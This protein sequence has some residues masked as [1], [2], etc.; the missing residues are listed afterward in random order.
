MVT[1]VAGHPCTQTH[2][3]FLPGLTRAPAL[4][5][6][7]TLLIHVYFDINFQIQAFSH[8]PEHATGTFLYH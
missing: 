4:L 3:L 2:L 5:Q 8:N 7:Q 6:L 1:F